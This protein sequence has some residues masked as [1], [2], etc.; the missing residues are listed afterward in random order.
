MATKAKGKYYRTTLRH[1]VTG[2]RRDVYGKSRAERDQKAEDLRSAWAREIEDAESPYFF[3]YAAEWYRRV[4]PDMSVQRRAIVAREINKNLCPVIGE[5]KLHALTSD[6]VLDVLS[7]RAGKSRATQARTLQV[8]KRILHAAEIAGK[9]R[10]NPAEDVRAGGRQTAPREALTPAQE[11][12]LLSAVSG[13]TVELF[14]LLGLYT[15]LR[16]EEICGL[17]WKDVHLDPPAHID[18]R[19]ACRWVNNNA[20]EI[21]QELKSP[22]AWRTVPV[23]APLLPH[24]QAAYTAAAKGTQEPPGGLTVL[25]R[26]DGTPWS[27]QTFRAAWSAIDARTAGVVKL[28]RRDPDTGKMRTVEVRRRVGDPIPKHPGV[29]IS[30]DFAVTPHQLRHTYITKLIRGGVDPK[31]A[32]YLAGHETADVTMDIYAHYVGV[33]PED[34]AARVASVFK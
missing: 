11:A 16:R 5:K 8:L 6:D 32:Q 20:P 3:Q 23:P 1:P 31:T 19:Q 30:L 24:L 21:S 4:S 14:V 12:A 27:Y 15:G 18:V 25:S 33:T 28:Q 10:R 9:I 13:L 2:E 7:A 17:A 26:A 29:M 34:L 22:A